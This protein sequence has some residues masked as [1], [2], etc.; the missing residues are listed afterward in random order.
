VVQHY[1]AADL[2]RLFKIRGAKVVGFAKAGLSQSIYAE[3]KSYRI[4]RPITDPKPSKPS[5]S[6]KSAAPKRSKQGCFIWGSKVVRSKVGMK[7]D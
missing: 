3:L 6:P 5:S 1:Q 7:N 2:E 4:N